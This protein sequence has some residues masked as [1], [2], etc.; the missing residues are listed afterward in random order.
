MNGTLPIA[1]ARQ[2]NRVDNKLP[3]PRAFTYLSSLPYLLGS[4][5]KT[6][7]RNPYV[8][9]KP[10]CQNLQGCGL[11]PIQ[12]TP[13][14]SRG[15]RKRVTCSSLFESVGF[16]TSDGGWMESTKV[17]KKVFTTGGSGLVKLHTYFAL[18]WQKGHY[19][20]G[21]YDHLKLILYIE[22]KNKK[23]I[24]VQCRKVPW[25]RRIPFQKNMF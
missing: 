13:V 1:Y 16:F 5:P 11:G 19:K 25:K 14:M 4:A 7:K 8:G 18:Q 3:L 22:K 23:R 24:A 21:A 6:R 12:E 10:T 2:V 17:N 9:A 20:K 15:R